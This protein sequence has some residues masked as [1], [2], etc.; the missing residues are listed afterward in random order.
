M[1]AG[2]WYHLLGTNDGTYTS[3]YVNGILENT[4]LEPMATGSEN[5]FI[6]RSA[7]SDQFTNGSIDDIRI[8]NRVLTEVEIL[9]LYNE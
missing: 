6:G 7:S 9:Q 8:Y 1:E 2:N 4:F 5:S 3:L